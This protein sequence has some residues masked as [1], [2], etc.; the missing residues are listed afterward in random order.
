MPVTNMRSTTS[1][2]GSA[3]KKASS[4]GSPKSTIHGPTDRSRE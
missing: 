2:I 1:S 3:T 4:T